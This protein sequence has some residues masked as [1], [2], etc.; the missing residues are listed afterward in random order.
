[1]DTFELKSGIKTFGITV[2][3]GQAGIGRAFDTLTGILDGDNSARSYFGI[4]AKENGCFVYR[5]AAEEMFEGEG[6][7]YGFESYL[8]SSGHYFAVT[9]PEWRKNI[10]R[11]K[12]LFREMN[13][14]DRVDPEQGMIEWYKNEE[15]M[16][17][18]VKLK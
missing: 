18:M 5:A 3:N 4:V 14:D 9:L 10:H 17:C 12:D 16:I 7:L 13:C 2:L 15:E 8:I 6:E 11:I 1:M